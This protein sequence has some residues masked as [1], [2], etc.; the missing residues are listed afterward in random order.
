MTIHRMDETIGKE[1]TMKIIDIIWILIGIMCMALI[2]ICIISIIENRRLVVTR[3]RIH[4]SKIPKEFDGMKMVVLADLHN[5]CFGKENDQLIEKIRNEV[6]DYI[7]IAGDMLVARSGSDI[8]VPVRLIQALAQEYPIYYAKGN[9]ELRAFL[10][11]DTYGS[12]WED[13]KSAIQDCVYWL[14]NE[15]VELKASYASGSSD[16]EGK[17]YLTGLDLNAAYYERFRRE[18]MEQS[19]LRDELGVCNT[20]AYHILIAHH[21]AYFPAYAEWGADLVISGH[22][23]GG[24]IRLPIFGGVISPTVQFFPKYDRGRYEEGT[25]TMILSGG[26]GNHTFKFR[27]NNL[28]ELVTIEFQ[29]D[30][31]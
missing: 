8:K 9:H 6:P 2:V 23:H 4:S 31:E 12:I 19:Y 20:D 7:V 22:L 24:M 17:V 1:D 25:S 13:Y 18:P 28:P 16:S 15:T 21:P 30:A 11:P 29:S 14:D 26:L 3:Y 27:V 5:A 10:E